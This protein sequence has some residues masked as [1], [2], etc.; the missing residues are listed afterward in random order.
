[1]KVRVGL[2]QALRDVLPPQLVQKLRRRKLFKTAVEER[3]LGG[4]VY[5]MM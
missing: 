2:Q 1:M 3:Q 4:R 5:K